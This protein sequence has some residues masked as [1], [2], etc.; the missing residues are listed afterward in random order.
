MIS[1]PF[2][3]I[4]AIFGEI[5]EVKQRIFDIY[6]ARFFIKL[7]QMRN[8]NFTTPEKQLKYCFE[9]RNGVPS[10]NIKM[11]NESYINICNE[12]VASKPTSV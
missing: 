11:L 4:I 5:K 3:S 1:F 6:M 2:N 9:N 12:L 7:R 10:F 8:G